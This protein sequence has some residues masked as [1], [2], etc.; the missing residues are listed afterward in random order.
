MIVSGLF[1]C[2]FIS[3]Q[4]ILENCG[5]FMDDRFEVI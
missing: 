1:A 4:S 2:V 5:V 3:Y